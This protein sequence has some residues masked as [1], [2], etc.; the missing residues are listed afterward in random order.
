[1]PNSISTPRDLLTREEQCINY[2]N[3]YLYKRHTKADGQNNIGAEKRRLRRQCLQGG[4]LFLTEFEELTTV[5]GG[6][7]GRRIL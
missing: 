7:I 5:T 2:M 4:Q 3:T 6:F 1:M